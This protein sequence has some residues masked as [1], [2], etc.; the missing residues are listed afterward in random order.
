VDKVAFTGSTTTGRVVAHAAA[1]NL[2]KVT[3]ELGG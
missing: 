3:P 2:N 1:E